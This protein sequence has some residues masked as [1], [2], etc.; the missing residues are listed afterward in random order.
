[1]KIGQITKTHLRIAT[2][3]VALV[4]SLAATNA[5]GA[6]YEYTGSI[7]YILDTTGGALDSSG[8]TPGVST[9]TGTF[10]YN[11]DA[12]LSS[13]TTNVANYRTGS[14]TLI[15]DD[16]IIFAGINNNVQMVNNSDSFHDSFISNAPPTMFGTPRGETGAN[17]QLDLR[18]SSATVFDS[19][20]LPTYLDLADFSS[21][22]VYVASFFQDSTYYRI[23]GNIESFELVSPTPTPI[24]G[25]I[26]LLGIGFSGV[27]G[28][29][30]K[31]GKIA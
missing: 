9:F 29:R 15:I 20:A 4:L 28:V 16:S 23:F 14:I 7:S 24:P 21:A 31:Y 26:W 25:A 17:I 18:D 12:N 13:S 22:Q 10:D 3:S 8:I 2:I 27:V 11:P 19:T 6:M 5:V 1:M 30:K